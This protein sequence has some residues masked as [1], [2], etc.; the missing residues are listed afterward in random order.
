MKKQMII[1]LTVFGIAGCAT[2]QTNFVP[3][4]PVWNATVKVLDEVGRPLAG[5]DVTIGY[6]VPSQDASIATSSKKGRT[7]TNGMFHASEKS[8]TIELFFGAIKDGYYKSRFEYELGDVFQY[9]HNPERW[10]PSVTL[11]LKRIVNP[12]PMYAK[13]LNTHVPV[14]DKPTGFD[15]IAGDWVTPYGKGIEADINFTA[16]FDRHPDGESDFTLTVSFPKLG[17]GIQEFAVTETEKGSTLRSPHEA[18][19]NGYQPKWVQ[20]DN[21]KPGR[22]IETNRDH[23]RNYFFRV[24]TVLDEKG[25]VK[26]ALYGKIYGDFMQFR[27]YLNPTPNDRNVEFDPKRNLLKSLK[28]TEQVDAP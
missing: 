24:R 17:D 19:I 13:W 11:P 3:E 22:A 14:V 26:S 9:R 10:S 28:S 27:Y 2:G 25:N 23:N 16:H 15:L 4:T 7:D 18:P 5:A 6:H 12:I 8:T 1:A 21:R 20:N